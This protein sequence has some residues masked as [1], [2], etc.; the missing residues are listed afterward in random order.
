MKVWNMTEIYRGMIE[1]YSNRH[2]IFLLIGNLLCGLLRL[3]HRL[4]RRMP[5]FGKRRYGTGTERIALD[6][7][8]GIIL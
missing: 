3:E 6:P 8:S 4:E 7:I 1:N 5:A 2:S